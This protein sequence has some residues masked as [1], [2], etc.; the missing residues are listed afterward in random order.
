M[1]FDILKVYIF[2]HLMVNKTFVN[3]GTP[4]KKGALPLPGHSWIG[5][6]RDNILNVRDTV[7]V[8]VRNM[9]SFS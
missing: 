5:C 4:Y 2:P 8:W 9:I 3:M 1:F 6:G 7:I